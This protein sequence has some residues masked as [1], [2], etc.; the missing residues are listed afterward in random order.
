VEQTPEAVAVGGNAA[1][2]MPTGV[3]FSQYALL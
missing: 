3:K 2:A 1:P